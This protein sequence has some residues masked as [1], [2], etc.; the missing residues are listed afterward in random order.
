MDSWI[1]CDRPKAHS[2]TILARRHRR[3]RTW[4]HRNT[5]TADTGVVTGC[6]SA[7][8]LFWLFAAPWRLG[9]RRPYDFMLLADPFAFDPAKLISRSQH[10]ELSDNGLT[11]IDRAGVI[12]VEFRDADAF[13][14][15]DRRVMEVPR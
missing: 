4:E 7:D 3:I 14:G 5:P 12:C 15:I 8:A 11:L 2:H 13:D 9:T 6:T 1:S 10:H